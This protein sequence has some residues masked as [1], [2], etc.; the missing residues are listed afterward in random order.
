MRKFV[1]PGCFALIAFAS[2]ASA[3]GP[4][5]DPFAAL[6]GEYATKTHA[7]L[8]KYCLDCH[9]AEEPAG[10]LNLVQFATLAQ[11]RP[12]ASVWV[13]VAEMLDN[14]EM[15]PKD[16]E[17][18]PAAERTQLR[19]WIKRYLDA[20]ALA[21][22]GDPGPVVLRRLNNAQYT[23][24]LRDLT[25]VALDPAREFPADGAAGEGF[26]NT[27]AALVMSPALLTKYLD[28]GKDVARHVVLV[29][30][31][32]HFSPSVN[33]RDWTDEALARIR[34][35]YNRYTAD[36]GATEINLH[37]LNW[38]TNKGGRLPVEKYLAATL[39]EREQ[40]AKGTKTID[41]VAAE[42]G[43]NAKYLGSLWTLLNA[44][45]PS[46]LLDRVRARWRTAQPAD[47]AALA[48]EIA[49]WQSA[50]VSFQ[51]VGHMKSWMNPVNPLTARRE[52]RVK[53]PRP[54]SGNVVTLHLAA[55]TAGDAGTAKDLVVWENPRL[56][57]PGRPDL[58]LRDVRNVVVELAARRYR[59]LGSTARALQAADAA[60]QGDAELNVE[61]LAKANQLDT[62]ALLAWFDYLGLGVG[63]ELKL[64]LLQGRIESSAG[65]DFVKGWGSGET[66]SFMANA[67]DQHVRIPGNLKGH[68]VV[69]HPSPTLS[70]A[71]G[72]KSPVAAT[73][74]IEGAVTH[75]HPECGNG[76]TWT[77][78]LQRGRTRQTL[79]S[80]ISH[81]ATPVPVGPIES[82]PVRPGDLVSLLIGPRDGNHAC[83]LT[84]IELKL[85]NTADQAV[86]SLSGDVS[87]DILAANPHADRQGHADVWYCYTRPLQG[88]D[89]GANIPAGS[90]LAR[91]QSAA[92]AAEKQSLALEVQKLLT[93]T[94]PADANH[95]DAVLHRQLAS[96]GGPLF[97]RT[98]RDYAKRDNTAA[99]ANG[100]WGLTPQRFGH[101]EDGSA[102]GAG[103]LSLRAPDSLE[104]RLPAELVADSE[105]VASVVIDPQD[106]DQ[107]AVQVFAGL[108]K[109]QDLGTL[110]AD[111][112]VLAAAD[113]A[114][115]KRFLQ[116]FN[117]F[118]QW[119][120]RAMCYVQIVPV[121]EV[122]T[123][124][125]FHREDEPL[126]RLMLSDAEQAELE[127]LWNELH[128]VSNDAL[129]LVD[130]FQQLMEFATQ[131]SD[132]GLFEP[133]RKPIHDRA[134]AFRQELIAAEPKQ[135]A[136]LIEFAGLV[137]R[138]PLSERESQE[139]ST[140]YG[141]L[142]EEGLPHDEAFRFTMARMFV[143]PAFLYRLEQAPQGEKPGPVS[144]WELANRL[145]YF[146]WSS[147]PDE[148]LR[149]AAVGGNLHQPEI[150]A[151]QTRRMLSDAK[152]RRLATEFACQWL[153]IYE[154]DTLDE[155]S[156]SHFPEFTSLRGDMY[157]EAILF[158]TD[159]FQ[160]DRSVLSILDA[161]HSFVNE[162]LAKFYG[163]PNVTGAEWRRI[164]NAAEFHRGGI[165]TLAA[166]LA[167]HSGASRTSPTL[168]GNWVAEVL[169]DEKL[170]KPPKDVPLL[171]EDEA[172]A[173]LTV[174]Q[175]VEKHAT[176]ARCSGCHV[177]VDPLGF[178]LESFDAIGRFREKDSA[179]RPL[180]LST[181]LASGTE[182][183]G[184]EGLRNH[185]LTT[186]RDAVLR[187]FCSKLLGYALGRGVVLSDEPLLAEMQQQL[188]A[189]DYRFS[190]AVE[191]IVRSPQFLEIRGRDAKLPDTVAAD[192]ETP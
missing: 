80:G 8:A 97:A 87:G 5:A 100:E 47:A 56:V 39:A 4:A 180:D 147:L 29:E 77:L 190:A 76:V 134:A 115:Q 153:H 64:D 136:K 86:W 108:A 69:V 36:V 146:L 58:P 2:I 162:S 30:D 117:D 35:I 181:R 182:M 191:A 57:A 101:R 150:L 23:Y 72:W 73:V 173:D 46:L 135:L 172:A 120:P 75:A 111:T 41:A 19:D 110:R 38:E 83:D 107:G 20:E 185:L 109:P 98:L 3:A 164:D 48:N 179:G 17:Q 89:N 192:A 49:Q 43:L 125:L 88:S 114:A 24:T 74:R 22:A 188:A 184:L 112:P 94:P 130:A 82:L 189:K 61:E 145:S 154:F 106:A 128:F 54:E 85:T 167:K 40:L 95:P 45:E 63:A 50:L 7:L 99:P 37:G 175:L 187:Q 16:A 131:D 132:P 31:G 141:K 27:G 90:V 93:G 14:G 11:V 28:A 55:G 151:A 53:I 178:T 139:L 171:P 166:T 156:E 71:A 119:F 104:I 34:G 103:D 32:F 15:P 33:R 168:R 44:N 1:L 81:G 78:E 42:R 113:S 105:F 62:D 123:L 169:L 152:T 157:E 142:R 68:G 183:V 124:T 21:S 170:P 158:F 6:G 174:R 25:G 159:L 60:S 149:T 96:L 143:A 18:M 144:D 165:L 59:F 163:I 51:S 140:L 79:A 133:Y 65:Y 84:D 176:D 10:D 177:R 138:R 121:D 118:R 52:V 148:S 91:W 161:K 126:R 160:H 127:R 137:Y 102:I 155:K 186:R 13:K 129:T 92:T 67:S 70:V 26:T 66:P 122:V 12:Q 9:A 116:A